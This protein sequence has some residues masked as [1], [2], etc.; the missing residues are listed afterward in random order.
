MYDMHVNHKLY[1]MHVNHELVQNF[2]LS[3]KT[4]IVNHLGHCEEIRDK[5]KK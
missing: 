3:R 5:Y 2:M 1:D 4:R